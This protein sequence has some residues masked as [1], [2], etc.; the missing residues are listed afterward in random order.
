MKRIIILL[1]VVLWSTSY[2]QVEFSTAGFF[3][4]DGSGRKVESMNP[5]WQFH[6]G[7]VKGAEAVQF[8]DSLWSTVSLPNGMEYLPVDASGGI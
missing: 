2:A 5:V 1:F 7:D 6:K 8:N 3:S 4:L